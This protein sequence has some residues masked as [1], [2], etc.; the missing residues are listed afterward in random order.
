MPVIVPKQGL[1]KETAQLL[2]RL[3]DRPSRDIRTTTDAG[4]ITFVVSDALYQKYLKSGEEEIT[5]KKPR[6]RPRGS[7]DQA[8][9]RA[10]QPQ[11]SDDKGEE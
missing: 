8:L 7:W 9:K 3:A 11:R 2:L 6:G 10:P 4:P 5:G 1:E